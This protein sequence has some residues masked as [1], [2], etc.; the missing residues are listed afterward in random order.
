MR[1]TRAVRLPK[2]QQ[3]F[4]RQLANRRA[5]LIFLRATTPQHFLKDGLES[6]RDAARLS[7][8][9][10]DCGYE[11]N[12]PQ[13]GFDFVTLFGFNVDVFSQEEQRAS[14]PRC[15]D[16]H[17]WVGEYRNY[18]FLLL[19]CHSARAQGLLEFS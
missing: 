7:R 9:A 10:A 1:T 15:P 11:E 16:E 18:V 14:K 6:V 13:D 5:P 19:D 17:A 12:L 2:W 4:W 8:F 3:E